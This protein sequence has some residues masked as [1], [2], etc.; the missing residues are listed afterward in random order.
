MALY[1]L[2]DIVTVDTSSRIHAENFEV[3]FNN[4]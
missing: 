4:I 1:C 3:K 2:C